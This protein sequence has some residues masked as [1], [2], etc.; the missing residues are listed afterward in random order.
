[1]RLRKKNINT[2]LLFSILIIIFESMNSIYLVKSIDVFE[3]FIQKNNITFNEYISLN[4]INYFSSVILFIIF[5]LYN[6]LFY[7]KFRVNKIYKGAWSI[8]I[9]G[10]ILFKV[11]VYPQDSLFYY[12]SIIMQIILIIYILSLKEREE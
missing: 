7:E 4:M 5:S 12:L 6:Y 10:V 2:I 8:L 11:F 3:K 9:L 1:M